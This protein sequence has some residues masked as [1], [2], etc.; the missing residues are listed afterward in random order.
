MDK[1]SDVLPCLKTAKLQWAANTNISYNWSYL[2]TNSCMSQKPSRKQLGENTMIC[3]KAQTR[4]ITPRLKKTEKSNWHHVVQLQMDYVN[5]Y[6]MGKK[7]AGTRHIWILEKMSNSVITLL[8]D[9]GL[10]KQSSKILH[11]K[12]D[13]FTENEH[14]IKMYCIPLSLQNLNRVTSLYPQLFKS[15]TYFSLKNCK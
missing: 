11:N 3:T 12:H 9:Q 5:N 10:I 14:Q 6:R 13:I 4:I 15:P 2:H 8:W 1:T 7:L